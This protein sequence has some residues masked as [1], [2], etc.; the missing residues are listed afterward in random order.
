M[1]PN[2]ATI[3]RKAGEIMA[4]F[5]E[6]KGESDITKKHFVDDYVKAGGIDNLPELRLEMQ[7]VMHKLKVHQL[8]LEM[9]QE[10]LNQ[11][12]IQLEK[13]REH[14]NYLYDFSP[15]GHISLSEDGVIVEINLTCTKIFAINRSNLLGARLA[16]FIALSDRPAFKNF[17]NGIFVH[18]TADFCEVEFINQ[19]THR[20]LRIDGVVYSGHRECQATVIDLTGQKQSAFEVKK[21]E[22]MLAV[23]QKVE[24]MKRFSASIVDDF[25]ETIT[26]IVQKIDFV[27]QSE[28]LDAANSAQ[29]KA[30]IKCSDRLLDVSSFLSAL[31]LSPRVVAEKMDINVVISENLNSL[32]QLVGEKITLTFQ[33]S[34]NPSL[35]TI[36]RNQLKQV[37]VCVVENAKDSMTSGGTLSIKVHHQHLEANEVYSS[38]TALQGEFVCLEISDT[39]VGMSKEVLDHL[40]EPFFT[41]RSNGTGLGIPIVRTIMKQNMGFVTVDS[42]FGEGTTVRLYLPCY[43]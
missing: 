32:V 12:N 29:L 25:R 15:I 6:E 39:G 2:L 17:L 7:R 24:L 3:S 35:V 36:D 4:D 11:A 38:A 23:F 10:E 20:F 28:T 33:D 41:T 26:E 16:Q 34:S 21:M 43:P 42:Q 5:F 31:T 9:Q 19:Q 40:F 37:L 13:S 27:L 8:E 30:A 14:Y 18:K 22:T 1:L